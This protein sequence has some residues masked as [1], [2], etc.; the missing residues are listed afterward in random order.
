VCASF[1]LN[2]SCWFCHW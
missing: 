2:I 1:V